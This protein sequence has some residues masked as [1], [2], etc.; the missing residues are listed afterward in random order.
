MNDQGGQDRNLRSCPAAVGG[1]RSVQHYSR[2]DA[3]CNGG[4]RK[5]GW[6]DE[7]VLGEGPISS[8]A[9]DNLDA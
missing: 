5:T 7:P 8:N 3:R 4:D 1:T 2:R 6:T 9:A